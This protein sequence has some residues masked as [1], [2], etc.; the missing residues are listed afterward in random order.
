MDAFNVV[1]ISYW[2]DYFMIQHQYDTSKTAFIVPKKLTKDFTDYLSIPLGQKS[3]WNCT[4]DKR[5]IVSVH[6]TTE[7]VEKITDWILNFNFST[8]NQ[9]G[10]VMPVFHLDEDKIRITTVNVYCS[11]ISQIISYI[12]DK[13]SVGRDKVATWAIDNFVLF[14]GKTIGEAIKAKSQSI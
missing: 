9:L 14:Y 4:I 3:K 13:E 1:L 5:E 12:L 8:R 6:L 7:E 10:L 2:S 11:M